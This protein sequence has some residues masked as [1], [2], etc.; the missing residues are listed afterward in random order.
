MRLIDKDAVI[1]ILKRD[2]ADGDCMTLIADSTA[3]EI[4]SLPP[5]EEHVL[6]STMG[7]LKQEEPV[8][9][10]VEK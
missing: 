2:A 3:R 6:Q 4:E 5:I 9:N 7:Q 8:N 10:E 1:S